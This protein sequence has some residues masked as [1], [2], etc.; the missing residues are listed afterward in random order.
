M[1]TVA[2][3][4]AQR[5]QFKVDPFNK[6]FS[7]ASDQKLNLNQLRLCFQVTLL[8]AKNQEIWIK[9]VVSDVIYNSIAKRNL[10]IRDLSDDCASVLGH[11]KII[12]LCEKLNLK[13]RSDIVICFSYQDKS[14]YSK[15]THVTH[16]L[17]N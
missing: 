6:G 1:F 5:E 10:I 8:P 12:I 11:K 17:I 16:V 7:F 14:K 4:L 15:Q 9:P 13:I 2:E 3:S